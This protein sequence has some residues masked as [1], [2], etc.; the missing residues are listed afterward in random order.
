M[1]RLLSEQKLYFSYDIVLFLQVEHPVNEQRLDG[2]ADN[3]IRSVKSDL[4]MRIYIYSLCPSSHCAF[5]E[6]ISVNKRQ[7][8]IHLTIPIPRL[9][10]FDIC[11]TL[12]EDL[13]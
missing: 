6:M 4:Q 9:L 11:H 13:L 3:V 12:I 7:P 5:E 10:T 1:I 8:W 2:I